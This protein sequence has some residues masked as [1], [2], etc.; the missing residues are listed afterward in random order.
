[1]HKSVQLPDDFLLGCGLTTLQIRSAKLSQPELEGPQVAEIAEKIR[2]LG[3][4]PL[5]YTSCFIS[6]AE[7][8][9]DF[10]TQL[11]GDLRRKRVPSWFA[12]HDI[13]GGKK[14]HEQIV[15]AIRQSERVLLVLS[16]HSMNSEWVKTEV[17]NAR[18]IE[19]LEKRHVLFPIRL[20]S[21]E[22]IK[23]W[24][25]FD[26]DIG[27]ESAKEVRE[28]FIPNFSNW[29]DKVSYENALQKLIDDLSKAD[30][31]KV[32]AP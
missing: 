23:K 12:P 9:T 32:R 1:V 10:A 18:K 2:N 6:Y 20:V 25:C 26:A 15:D 5:Q 27:K 31:I 30:P 22:A 24:E 28:Y 19:N 21:Y 11:H 4:Q 8:D 13:R 16:E 29:R 17:A 14:L 3:D 7:E